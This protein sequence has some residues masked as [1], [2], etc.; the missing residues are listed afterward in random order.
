MATASE[1]R[2]KT[3]AELR[4][5]HD[6][7][8][9]QANYVVETVE[10]PTLP[11]LTRAINAGYS[12]GSAVPNGYARLKG[13]KIKKAIRAQLSKRANARAE[14]QKMEQDPRLYLKERFLEHAADEKVTAVQ[15]A[16]LDALAKMEGLYTQKIEVDVGDKTRAA[17]ILGRIRQ[18]IDPSILAQPSEE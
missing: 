6:L 4:L 8:E 5:E 17:W 1:A 16:S 12:Q 13:P 15:H 14:L 18:D 3:V 11:V 10:R 9:K 7:S 2:Q